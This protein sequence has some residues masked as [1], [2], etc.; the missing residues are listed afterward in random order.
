MSEQREIN[1]IKKQRAREIKC[2]SE[3]DNGNINAKK[4][5]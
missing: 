1:I 4:K 2:E 5:K 3:R